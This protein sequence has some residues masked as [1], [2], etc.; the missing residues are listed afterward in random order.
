LYLCVE[1]QQVITEG[2]YYTMP[3]FCS[4]LLRSNNEVYGRGPGIQAMPEI[5]LVNAMEQDI[6]TWTELMGNPPW[7]AP[8]GSSSTPDGR[9]GGITYWDA[10]NP[11]NKP[12]QV[13]LKNR[14]DLAETKTEQKRNRIRRAFH[15]DL[16]QLLTNEQVRQKIKTATEVQEMVA[17]KLLLFS[18]LFARY[19]VEKLTPML[20]RVLDIGIRSG[21]VDPPP[22]EIQG[23]PY[24]V[25]YVSKIALAIKAAETRSF[26]ALANLVTGLSPFVPGIMNVVDWN[27]GVRDAASSFGVSTKLIRSDREVATITEQQ[28]RQAMAMQAA[29]TAEMASRTVKNMGPQAQ[30]QA[31]EELAGV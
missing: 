1:D 22:P 4:R 15:N 17:E 5:R 18:P 23:T 9:P 19:T 31:T 13:T 28:Q 14:V 30:E 8:D 2:G 12:E 3:A 29:Q 26:V 11:N 21:L 20:E 16:F 10:S 24:Q 27:Q 7:L 6:L 25:A